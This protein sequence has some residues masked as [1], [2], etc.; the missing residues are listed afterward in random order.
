MCTGGVAMRSILT[1]VSAAL[2]VI[3]L[4]TA[5]WAQNG[6]ERFEKDIKPQFE[7]KKF[8]Y[9]SAAPL[10][11]S[12]FVLNDVVAVVPANQA[13]G[14]K[15][16]TVKIHKVTVEELDF[17]RLKKSAK[18]DEAPRFANLKPLEINMRGEAKITLALVVDGISDK[19]GMAGAKDDG[20][21]RSASL[22]IDDS[23]LL[24]K[25]LTAYAKEEGTKPDEIVQSLRAAI[26]AFAAQQGPA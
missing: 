18:D 15:E 5:S 12:G 13:T 14:D 16:S 26:A 1:G 22:A 24:A 19:S 9:A 25:L 11:D 3:G 6:L 17:D 10:G 2:L 8:S 23:G 20:K 21:L 7:L 4:A